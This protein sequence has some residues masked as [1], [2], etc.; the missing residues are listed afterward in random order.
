MSGFGLGF[1]FGFYDFYD[2][3]YSS[4]AN[5]SFGNAQFVG[6]L[7][8]DL[9]LSG[10]VGSYRYDGFGFYNDAN[11]FFKFE[12]L[13]A[14]SVVVKSNENDVTV[15]LYDDRRRYLGRL[16]EDGYGGDYARAQ[17]DKTG[18]AI[19]L[20]PG[21]YYLR[22]SSDDAT[23]YRINVDAAPDGD[24]R[25]AD[26]RRLDQLDCSKTVGG[27]VGQLDLGDS[28][29]FRP[30]RSGPFTLSQTGGPRRVELQ[31]YDDDQ[32][33][34]ASSAQVRRS[35]Q[36]DRDYYLRVAATNASADQSYRVTL[37]PNP[38]YQGTRRADRLTGCADNEIFRGL[39]GSDR[40]TGRKGDDQLLGGADNDRLAGDAGNDRLSGG[41]GFDRLIGGSGRDIFVLGGSDGDL[42]RD[43]QLGIDRLELPSPL[44]FSDLS[45][46][47]QGQT[48]VLRVG[49]SNL[50]N[51]M[52]IQVG[53]LSASDFFSL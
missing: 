47:Q 1:G 7:G 20:S 52:G 35:L 36:D 25:L 2:S 8:T 37:A 41:S 29:R 5:G 34:L 40:L 23:S 16:E 43:F 13:S 33:L 27:Q 6:G 19:S 11:D 22:V 32:N 42:I 9:F 18:L 38:V 45:L 26:A 14:R 28:Y 4:D 39:A 49:D 17:G 30:G 10:N 15:R 53:Q 21:N 24:Y 51:L 12:L 31:L 3:D 44:T 48:V 50:A 46:T